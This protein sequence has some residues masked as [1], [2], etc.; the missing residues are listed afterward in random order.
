M[1]ARPTAAT[2]PDQ[3]KVAANERYK[4]LVGHLTERMIIAF[5]LTLHD[6]GHTTEYICRAL[7]DFYEIVDGYNEQAQAIL[8]AN[9]AA[10]PDELNR[11]LIQE[12]AERG[13]IFTNNNGHME[14]VAKPH[15]RKKR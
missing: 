10:S 6:R 8:D 7:A 14:L 1:K 5:A 9:P 4:Q 3:F 11:P 15:K 13:V 12:A 2:M